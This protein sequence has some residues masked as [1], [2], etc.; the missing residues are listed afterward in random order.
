MTDLLSVLKSD[1]EEI[2]SGA[3]K[4]S[5]NTAFILEEINE[6]RS[7]IE[8][9]EAIPCLPETE[10]QIEKLNCR[11]ESR[12]EF[13][14]FLDS[15]DSETD[16]NKIDENNLNSLVTETKASSPTTIS[17]DAPR[18]V[19]VGLNRYNEENILP[20]ENQAKSHEIQLNDGCTPDS[21]MHSED[22]CHSSDSEF[23]EKVAIYRPNEFSVK[24]AC[25][26]L[27]IKEPPQNKFYEQELF[28][29]QISKKDFRKI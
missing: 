16:E 7:V 26:I 14:V 22:S 11:E 6:T 21:K 5:T 2:E 17:P 10:S 3:T 28:D 4:A 29:C 18:L 1:L 15:E 8:E 9:G 12:N 13:V 25:D 20:D 24:D 27:N 23:E 19:L